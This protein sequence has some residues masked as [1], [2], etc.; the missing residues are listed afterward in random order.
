MYNS[1][2]VYGG[3]TENYIINQLDSAVCSDDDIVKNMKIS[4]NGVEYR[5][6]PTEK[7]N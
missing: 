3:R 4:I 6:I 5:L 7:K 1:F 2:I